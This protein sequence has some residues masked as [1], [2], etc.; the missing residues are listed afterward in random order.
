MSGKLWGPLQ[1]PGVCSLCL[2]KA[3]SG[4]K[5]E[6]APEML[7][8]WEKQRLRQPLRGAWLCSPL[9]WSKYAQT[10]HLGQS[11]AT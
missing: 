11:P 2:S 5:K 10:G 6:A 4:N 7:A 8:A 3:E 1:A 9:R